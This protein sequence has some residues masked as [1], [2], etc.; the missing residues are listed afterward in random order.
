VTVAQ[1]MVAM[2][3]RQ[4]DQ[5]RNGGFSVN[6]ADHVHVA[7]G[8]H[9]RRTVD[10]AE[11]YDDA[12]AVGRGLDEVGQFPDGALPAAVHAHRGDAVQRG[13]QPPGIGLL[14]TDAGDLARHR[15]G[16]CDQVNHRRVVR[17]V[18]GEGLRVSPAFLVADRMLR[19]RRRDATASVEQ[20]VE[21]DR[22]RARLTVLEGLR[23]ALD[24]L[25]QRL[26]FDRGHAVE[27]RP[28]MALDAVRIDV[29]HQRAGVA[30]LSGRAQAVSL[31]DAETARALLRPDAPGA[32][33]E[34]ERRFRRPAP[35]H[36]LEA[37][38]D[39]GRVRDML[40]GERAQPVDCFR[41]VAGKAEAP[42]FLECRLAGGVRARDG[43]RLIHYP[44]VHYSVAAARSR[45]HS[46]CRARRRA[47]SRTRPSRRAL[48]RAY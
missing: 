32:S 21:R 28:V 30:K 35:M 41:K 42:H 24:V 5:H 40:L 33:D 39:H 36:E 45:R 4:M 14:E 23:D 25:R 46:R 26:E 47:A 15:D 3:A 22:A 6:L 9:P 20:R 48:W 34:F 17:I 10:N 11:L 2:L 29:G 31:D 43:I 27:D 1:E 18:C 19:R 12:G 8:E 37:L 44:F 16:I 38:R 13:A 7:F